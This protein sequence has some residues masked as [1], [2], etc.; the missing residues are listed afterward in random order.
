MN[1]LEICLEEELVKM[2]VV[3]CW[4]RV[5]LLLII[6]MF[7]FDVSSMIVVVLFFKVNLLLMLIFNILLYLII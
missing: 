3:F 7:E 5:V 1:K 2:Y 4:F 6:E